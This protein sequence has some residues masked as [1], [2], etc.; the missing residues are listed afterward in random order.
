MIEAIVLSCAFGGLVLL[1]APEQTYR[2]VQ[3]SS[4]FVN[5]VTRMIE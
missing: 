2:R 3:R 1:L 4:K 5:L